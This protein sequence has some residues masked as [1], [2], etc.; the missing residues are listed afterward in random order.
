MITDRQFDQKLQ[1]TSIS[2]HA[3]IHVKPYETDRSRCKN[4]R[5]PCIANAVV[6]TLS[7]ALLWTKFLRWRIFL[8]TE[9]LNMRWGT[10]GMVLY[11]LANEFAWVGSHWVA[12]LCVFRIYHVLMKAGM[13]MIIYPWL[14]PTI[15]GWSSNTGKGSQQ[16][17]ISNQWT[18]YLQRWSHA[19]RPPSARRLRGTLKR[20][21]LQEII[22]YLTL[23]RDSQN[24]C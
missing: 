13:S 7:P 20:V 6:F 9:C 11:G 5:W 3:E 8:N 4:A 19:T 10:I 12:T 21:Y 24:I 15:D 2:M 23:V 17:S 18:F 22:A 1:D 14:S 16:N